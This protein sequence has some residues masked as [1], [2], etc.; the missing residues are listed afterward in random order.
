MSKFLYIR[1]N[2]K[3]MEEEEEDGGG[4]GKGVGK[5][6]GERKGRGRKE[7]K[8]ERKIKSA[9]TWNSLALQWL[10]LC[11][12]NAGGVG[13]IPGWGAKIPRALQPKP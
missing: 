1:V 8:R 13:L 5:G 11:T 9:R 2:K 12:S 6:E 3:K 4:G 10:R 7:K